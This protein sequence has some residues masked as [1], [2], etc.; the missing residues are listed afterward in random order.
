MRWRQQCTGPATATAAAA[1]LAL[2][3]ST[4]QS[5][6]S[7][8]PLGVPPY[9]CMTLRVATVTLY[10]VYAALCTIVLSCGV[11]AC[12]ISAARRSGGSAGGLQAYFGGVMGLS[13]FVYVNKQSF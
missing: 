1:F 4:E 2:S 12:G 6:K 7:S 13:Q 8:A 9:I 3:I 11:G 5:A 10:T